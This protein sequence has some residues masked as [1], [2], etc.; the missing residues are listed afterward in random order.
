MPS[1]PRPARAPRSSSCCRRQRAPEEGAA[2]ALADGRAPNKRSETVL[3]V[4]DEAQVRELAAIALQRAGFTVLEAQHPEEAFEVV[5]RHQGPLHLI[6]TD[7][8]MPG[9]NGRVMVERLIRR[10]PDAR[11]LFMSGYTDDALAP[12]G[13]A[14]GDMAFLNKPFTPKQLAERVR[15]VLDAIPS[16]A[17][18]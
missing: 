12:H 3:L 1:I 7:V 13:V 14:P 10:F 18:A 6:L 2:S 9:M 11:I 4:E 15:E 16:S 8:V 5:A 17:V